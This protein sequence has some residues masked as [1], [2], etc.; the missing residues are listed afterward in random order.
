[1]WYN[2]PQWGKRIACEKPVTLSRAVFRMRSTS[3]VEH[4]SPQSQNNGEVKKAQLD[5]FGNLALISVSENSTYSDRDPIE[6][7]GIFEVRQKKGLIQSLKLA[8][9]F[10]AFGDRVQDW[11]DDA[12]IKHEESMVMVLKAFH[13]EWMATNNDVKA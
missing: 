1:L 12:M 10:A 11:D 4:V 6:K 13:P 9:I 7:K 3:S 8:H 2:Q 5:R